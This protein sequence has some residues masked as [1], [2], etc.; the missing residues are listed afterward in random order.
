MGCGTKCEFATLL[1]PLLWAADRLGGSES[2]VGEMKPIVLLPVLAA[3]IAFW[4]WQDARQASVDCRHAQMAV[5][6]DP[7]QQIFL[8]WKAMAC[9]K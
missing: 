8:E 3:F 9:L 7:T 2:D 4:F 5:N 1:C 6:D